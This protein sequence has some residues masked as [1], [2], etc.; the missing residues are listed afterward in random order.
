M[1]FQDLPPEVAQHVTKQLVAL[2]AGDATAVCNDLKAWCRAHPVACRDPTVWRA[3]FE[4]LFIPSLPPA[5]PAPPPAPAV[6]TPPSS[7]ADSES[8]SD[9]EWPFR[10]KSPPS[11]YHQAVQKAQQ[12][13]DKVE[14]VNAARAALDADP[15][16]S[17]YK[18]AFV[19][20]C[21]RI[22]QVKAVKPGAIRHVHPALRRS[23][24]FI[25]SVAVIDARVIRYGIGFDREDSEG[26]W[27]SAIEAN[28]RNMQYAMIYS[29]GGVG[30]ISEEDVQDIACDHPEILR[31]LPADYEIDICNWDL[32]MELKEHPLWLEH[33]QDLEFTDDKSLMLELANQDGCTLKFMRDHFR[34]D[35]RIVLAAL[36]QAGAVAFEWV[37]GDALRRDPDVR[38]LAGLQPFPGAERVAYASE[39]EEEEE[40]EDDDDDD[41]SEEE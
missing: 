21:A 34:G 19:D 14:A 5:P 18:D 15:P 16:A 23:E 39:C 22:D 40:E 28:P 7:P 35:K 2:N 8:D 29:Y 30:H 12:Y 27:R 32:P 13:A 9:D 24:Y 11:A 3:A 25:S 1:K 10:P 4:A 36:E 31:Y 38:E 6:P 26:M 17:T 37:M 41:M 20:V 33:M